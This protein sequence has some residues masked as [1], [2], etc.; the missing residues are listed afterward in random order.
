MHLSSSLLALLLPAATQASLQIVPGASWTAVRFSYFPAHLSYPQLTPVPPPSPSQSDGEHLNAHG[1]GIIRVNDTFYLIGEDKAQGSAFQNINCYSS[2]DLVQWKFE[3]RLLSRQGSGDLGP[4]RIVERPKVIYNDRTRQYV[5][6]MHIDSSDYKDARVG[7][8]VGDQ[9][10]GS[11]R[12]SHW[13]GLAGV[14]GKGMLTG[15]GY[16]R[17]FRP[18]GFQSRDMGLFKDDDGTAYLLTEDV[19]LPYYPS[20]LPFP[21]SLDHHHD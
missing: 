15:V 5:M 17:S 12:R 1:A 6:W 18:L 14:S 11:Y 4:N 9:V 8:A 10:C 2:R 16:L 20:P 3:G 21:S 13:H 7:V 19:R